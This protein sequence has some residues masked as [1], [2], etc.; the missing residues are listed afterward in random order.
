MQ[1]SEVFNLISHAIINVA[2]SIFS[3]ERQSTKVGCFSFVRFGDVWGW[4]EN[5]SPRRVGVA[6]G[7][8]GA[9][10]AERRASP[11]REGWQA[12]PDGVGH[13]RSKCIG[14][15]KPLVMRPSLKLDR[16]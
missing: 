1:D 13:L 7:G 12:K 16:L 5:P 15:K 14:G 9:P 3:L 11:F 8:G 4:R 10:A 6:E 2:F